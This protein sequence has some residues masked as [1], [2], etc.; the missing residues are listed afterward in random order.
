MSSESI[1]VT[2][3][4]QRSTLAAVRSL[5]RAGWRVVVTAGRPRSLA[6]ASRWC[7]EEIIVPD[8]LRRAPEFV[9]ALDREVQRLRPKVVIPMTEAAVLPILEA[10]GRWPDTRVPLP[11]LES[12]RAICDKEWVLREAE[13]IGI[14]TP[15]QFVLQSSEQVITPLPLRFPLVVKPA[16]SVA[17]EAGERTKLGV[18]HARS[19]DELAA[20][21][22]DMPA[23]AYP[24]LLQER[25]VGPGIGIFLLIGAGQVRA[26]FAHRRLREKP[27][28]GGVSVYRESVE[29]D[30]ELLELSRVL[31][32]RFGWEGVAMIEYKRDALTGRPY[33]ME[34]NGRF[35]GSLQLA[36][37]AGV[38]F[39]RLLVDQ[40]LGVPA[41]PPP[42][43]RKG[44]RSRWWLGEVDHVIARLRKSDAELDLPEG[45]PS[46]LAAFSELF[47]WW[48]R[49]DMGEVFRWSDPGPGVRE[50]TQWLRPGAASRD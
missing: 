11:S 29:A 27:P 36:I 48:R 39:P 46:R 17:G 32:S 44:V 24:L 22:S 25:V 47:H 31:L 18:R 8:P 16:R 7:A 40:V 37:D 26:A 13:A 23:V 30:P 21:L 34:I 49:G 43:W 45:V 3:G 2:D 20:A 5:G 35:W 33:L 4:E 42:A 1:L 38:D 15:A 28:S 12:F 50:F 10:R 41:G 6:A 14:S 19:A 9:A